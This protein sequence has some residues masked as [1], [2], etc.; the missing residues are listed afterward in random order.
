[1][2]DF[3]K[4]L[5]FHKMDEMERHIAFKAQRNGYIFLVLALAVWPIYESCQVYLYH[6]R[7]NPVPCFLL[8]AATLVQSFSQLILTRNAVKDDE[9]S[10]ET[11][12]LAR[13][14]IL[15]CAAA[16]IIAAAVAA[17]VLLGVRV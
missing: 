3:L 16:G 10:Y 7:L 11:G 14:V 8:V 5:G 12:P 17:V 2:K 15:T 1:M 4:R 13:L 9:D 6:G